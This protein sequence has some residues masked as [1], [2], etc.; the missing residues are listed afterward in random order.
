M[1][2]GMMEGEI[3]VKEKQRIISQGRER[4]ENGEREE[5][6]VRWEE[7]ENE[8]RVQ[9]QGSRSHFTW[10]GARLLL[11][12]GMDGSKER[13]EEGVKERRNEGKKKRSLRIAAPSSVGC[14]SH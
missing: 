2:R 4:M 1:M 3:L 12:T 9:R 14:L 6:G 7:G 5:E 8:S 13:R 10:K 11:G